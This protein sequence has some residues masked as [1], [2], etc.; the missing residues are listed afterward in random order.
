MKGVDVLLAAFDE[1]RGSGPEDLHLVHAGSGRPSFFAAHLVRHPQRVHVLGFRHD[2]ERVIGGLDV[3]VLPS[4]SHEGLSQVL[5]QAMVLGVPVVATEAGGNADL[6]V[7]GATGILVR[8]E[9][10]AE[11]AVGIRRALELAPAERAALL[12]RARQLVQSEYSL[13]TVI[14][15][16]VKAYEQVLRARLGRAARTGPAEGHPSV[17]GPLASPGR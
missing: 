3:F 9:D 13:E 6:V 15:R 10:P 2:I 4:R 1:L 7:P 11:L 16:Y 17:R 5:C 8:P 12:A 14:S